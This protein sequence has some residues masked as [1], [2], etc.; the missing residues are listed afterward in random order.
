M[1]LFGFIG[2]GMASPFLLLPFVPGVRNLLPK[3]GDWMD[4]FKQVMGFVMMG[5]VIFFLSTMGNEWKTA[6]LTLLM[7]VAFACWWIGKVPTYE[8]V[9]KQLTAWVGGLAAAAL[10]GVAAFN[11]LGPPKH[12]IHWEKFSLDA[13]A[14]AEQEGRTVFVDFTADWCM[15]CKTN[16]KFSVES[17]AVQKLLLENNVVAMKADWTEANADLKSELDRLKRPSIPL[18]AVYPAGKPTEV[19]V[20]DGL[21]ME[22]Q[23]LDTIRR[24]GPSKV[25]LERK[26]G[27]KETETAKVVAKNSS[28]QTN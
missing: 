7:G 1:F 25:P 19:L 4:T 8:P 15:N 18:L 2:L 5:A 17:E 27:G 3:P 28:R 26:P 11:F 21:V 13:I 9:G 10:F 20:L 14:K 24:G 12:I 23:V 6:T 16:E 22:F